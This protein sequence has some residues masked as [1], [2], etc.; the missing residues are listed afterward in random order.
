VKRSFRILTTPN[1]VK[2]VKTARKASVNF[3][4]DTEGSHMSNM[5]NVN[6]KT[7]RKEK[8]IKTQLRRQDNIK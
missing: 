6:Q 3:V 4:K 2:V 5:H 7:W 1:L 8:K